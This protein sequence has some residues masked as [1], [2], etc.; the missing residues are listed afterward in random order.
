MKADPLAEKV[1]SVLE[2]RA[3]VPVM[4][5]AVLLRERRVM[6]VKV[7]AVPQDST[8]ISLEKIGSLGGIKGKFHSRCDY[9]ILF[10]LNGKD[11][12]VFIELKKK[13][14]ETSKGLEQLR[15]SLP[16]LTYLRSLCQVVF[17]GEKRNMPRVSIHYVLIGKRATPFFD[18]HRV[19]EVRDFSSVIHHGIEVR[20]VVGRLIQFD[21][22]WQQPL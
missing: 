6:D 11:A 9:L 7:V 20:I 8:V 3:R 17:N 14:R 10:R 4:D 15:M 21:Q 16:Y 1:R 13:I 18:K 22:L 19:S 5:G 12:A 2:E